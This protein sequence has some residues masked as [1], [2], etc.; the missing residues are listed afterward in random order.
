M[1]EVNVNCVLEVKTSGL[2]DLSFID[3]DPDD[4]PD[5]LDSI[6]T[7]EFQEQMVAKFEEAVA[8]KQAEREAGNIDSA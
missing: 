8:Q 1:P 7:R 6:G 4:L 3:V 5:L 2:I